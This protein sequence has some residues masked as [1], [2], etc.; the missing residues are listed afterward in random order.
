LPFFQLHPHFNPFVE[1]APEEFQQEKPEDQDRNR[2]ENL[3]CVI[4]AFDS[5]QQDRNLMN[6]FTETLHNLPPQEKVC[7]LS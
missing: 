6:N 3:P 5:F 4:T 2:Y 7:L 1:V